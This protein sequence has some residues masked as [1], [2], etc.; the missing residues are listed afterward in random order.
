MTKEA[1]RQRILSVTVWD[2]DSLKEN[3]FLGSIAIPVEKLDLDQET[4]AWFPLT[5]DRLSRQAS[6]LS[7]GW[8]WYRAID[9]EQPPTRPLTESYSLLLYIKCLYYYYIIISYCWKIAF[10]LFYSHEL[11]YVFIVLV[12]SIYSAGLQNLIECVLK[13]I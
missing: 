2:F 4:T 9:G 12:Q 8:S 13:R 5:S 1:V 11:L 10:S 3:E 7:R 6:R